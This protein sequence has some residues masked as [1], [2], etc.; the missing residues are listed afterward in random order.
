[1]SLHKNNEKSI[2]KFRTEI[3]RKVFMCFRIFS[4]MISPNMKDDNCSTFGRH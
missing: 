3:L 4:E 2:A 1:M